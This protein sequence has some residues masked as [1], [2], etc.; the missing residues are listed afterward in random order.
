MD[1]IATLDF[2]HF[3]P[4]PHI[5]PE[6]LL[7]PTNLPPFYRL[8]CD[9]QTTALY[10]FAIKG[11][12]SKELLGLYWPGD[13]NGD[14]K[15]KRNR[16]SWRIG[17][18][19][20]SNRP[21]YCTYQSCG[22]PM[23]MMATAET[24]ALPAGNKRP[25]SD[26][27]DTTLKL[28]NKVVLLRDEKDSEKVVELQYEIDQLKAAL[29]C[30]QARHKGLQNQM[31]QVETAMSVRSNLVTN[32]IVNYHW[33]V[34]NLQLLAPSISSLVDETLSNEDILAAAG[35]HATL[36]HRVTVVQELAKRL[37]LS[38]K[39][40]TDSMGDQEGEVPQIAPAI[41]FHSALNGN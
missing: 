27:G 38:V 41:Q 35:G 21:V 4:F 31:D 28:S 25:E 33:S 24:S 19:N 2:D 11:H 7:S 15:I 10:N 32:A 23:R 34:T 6:P 8:L 40:D 20:L 9:I 5:I 13:F 14:G 30:A 18:E 1:G 16:R 12:I 17:D 39:I 22:R 36:E 26:L 29:K 3:P 37:K